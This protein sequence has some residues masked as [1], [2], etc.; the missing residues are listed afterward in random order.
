MI[1]LKGGLSVHELADMIT[2]PETEIIKLLFFKVP[3]SNLLFCNLRDSPRPFAHVLR[4]SMALYG[5]LLVTQPFFKQ[6][7]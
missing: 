2:V 7:Y 1:T 3:F 6:F 4:I 5:Y